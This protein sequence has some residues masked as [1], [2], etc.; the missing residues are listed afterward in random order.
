MIARK[1]KHENLSLV[2]VVK[3]N[4]KSREQAK[5]IKSDLRTHSFH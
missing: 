4:Q 1:G 2:L 3:D 5:K